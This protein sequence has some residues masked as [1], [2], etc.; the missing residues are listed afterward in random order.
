MHNKDKN[1][2]SGPCAGQPCLREKV[3]IWLGSLHVADFI[4]C[5]CGDCF[6]ICLSEN[7]ACVRVGKSEDNFFGHSLKLVDKKFYR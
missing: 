5:L 1:S 6:F 3:H 7:V 4:Y 2:H